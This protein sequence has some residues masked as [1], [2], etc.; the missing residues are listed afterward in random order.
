M[1]RRQLETISDAAADRVL[2]A[3]GV[4]LFC[5]VLAAL[6]AMPNPDPALPHCP[7]RAE[8]YTQPH[9]RCQP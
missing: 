9:E 4:L 6:C 5:I 2:L 8:A 7:R 3:V 1:M